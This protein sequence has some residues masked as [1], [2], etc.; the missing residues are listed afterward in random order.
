MIYYL[1]ITEPLRIISCPA[2]LVP[3]RRNRTHIVKA[4]VEE[5]ARTALARFE[6]LETLGELGPFIP[7]HIWSLI[8]CLRTMT[9]ASR[10]P[11]PP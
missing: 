9:A 3:S 1:V 6:A 2:V 7:S 8:V 5:S 4:A 11:H 10:A